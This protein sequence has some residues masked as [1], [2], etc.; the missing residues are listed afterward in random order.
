[1]NRGDQTLCCTTHQSHNWAGEGGSALARDYTVSQGFFSR[2]ECTVGWK[3]KEFV[4]CR[5]RV[6]VLGRQ[7]HDLHID[8][9]HELGDFGALS[10]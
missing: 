3:C 9:D 2:Y 7:Y 8:Q 5:A 4:E 10:S 6:D 1:M